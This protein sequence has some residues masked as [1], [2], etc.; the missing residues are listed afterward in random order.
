MTRRTAKELWDALE[1]AGDEAELEEALALTPE[2]RR[3]ELVEAGY[4]LD[5]IHASADAFFAA[6]PSVA[7]AATE[8]LARSPAPPAPRAPAPAAVVVAGPPR[9]RMRPAVVVPI[10]LVLAAGVALAIRAALPT[11]V[12]IAPPPDDTPAGR[13]A[14]MRADA[15]RACEARRW[16]TCLDDLDQARSLDPAGDEA[17][18]VQAL[19]RAAGDVPAVPGPKP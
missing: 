18:E 4:D 17:P 15:R 16:Q 8:A 9:R 11:P 19:R 5:K 13:A 6:N 10:A 12:L 2:E 14:A 1:Q 7:A 3:R